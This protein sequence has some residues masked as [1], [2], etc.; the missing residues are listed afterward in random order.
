MI[1]LTDRNEFTLSFPQADA[2]QDAR[3]HADLELVGRIQSGDQGAF[4]DL[5]ERY[6]GRLFSVIHRILR[7][8]EDTEDTAQ[9][10]FTKVY[11]AIRNFD[12]RCSL[13]T[14]ICKIATNE[15]YSLMR[16]RRAQNR[17]EADA[18][19]YEAFATE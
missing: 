10:V 17:H 6:Q 15:C 3:R 9:Q 4:R 19:E 14:W 5:V 16:K 2:A 12:C 18:P 7:N 8:R 1:E 13:L 11:F